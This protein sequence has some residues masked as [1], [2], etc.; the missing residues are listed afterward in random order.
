MLTICQEVRLREMRHRALAAAAAWDESKHPRDRAGRFGEGVGGG[1]RGGR[2]G[3]SPLKRYPDQRH[4]RVADDLLDNPN[5]GIPADI[6]RELLADI[7]RLAAEQR[8]TPRNKKN[9][10]KL[11]ARLD[12]ESGGGA[13]KGKGRPR[14]S[15]GPD[16]RGVPRQN[17]V[18]L[19]DNV[20]FLVNQ[21]TSGEAERNGRLRI[22]GHFKPKELIKKIDK[23]GPADADPYTHRVL[24]HIRGALERAPEKRGIYG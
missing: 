18:T 20:Q 12:K 24:R 23:I 3:K 19:H 2:K 22:P 16:E 14:K 13:A 17:S 21:I 6:D 15:P 4:T 10:A 5:R 9:A 8:P 11:L 7:V 1:G